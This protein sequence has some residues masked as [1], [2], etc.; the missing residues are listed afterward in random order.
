MRDAPL[1]R[2]RSNLVGHRV[3]LKSNLQSVRSSW[4]EQRRQ[5]AVWLCAGCAACDATPRRD[6]PHLC[7]LGLRAS[8]L[9]LEKLHRA[10]VTLGICQ[11]LE[12]SKVAALARLGV[13]LARVKAILAT[14]QFADHRAPPRDRRIVTSGKRRTSRN[15]VC[16]CAT[17]RSGASRGSRLRRVWPAGSATPASRDNRPR[18]G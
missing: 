15:A 11:R 10:L 7:W 6:R 4:T 17:V 1:I 2:L 16:K 8:A 9:A 12:G 13:R 18:P 5:M 3:R 14:L